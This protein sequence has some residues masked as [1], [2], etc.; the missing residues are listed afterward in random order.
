[1]SLH[2]LCRTLIRLHVDE[3]LKNAISII[4][5]DPD[6]FKEFKDK[7]QTGGGKLREH[8]YLYRGSKVNIYEDNETYEDEII[9]SI[10]NNDDPKQGKCALIYYNKKEKCAHICEITYYSKCADKMPTKKGGTFILEFVID[11]IEK[12]MTK[13]KEVKYI[14]L[15]DNSKKYCSSTPTDKV[16]LWILCMLTKGETWYGEHGFVPVIP[17]TKKSLMYI[18]EKNRQLVNKKVG[19]VRRMK[20]YLMKSNDKDLNEKGIEKI[21]KVFKDEPIRKLFSYLMLNYE[22]KCGMFNKT[23]ENIMDDLGMENMDGF[24]YIKYIQ[25]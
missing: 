25:Q 11:F 19:D 21:L 4:R 5:N 7:K 8:T 16:P 6:F 22:S 18:Y 1:M 14:Q 13:T 15:K 10:F 24:T 2:N 17:E 3:P 9:Y 12:K 23:Y 20:E